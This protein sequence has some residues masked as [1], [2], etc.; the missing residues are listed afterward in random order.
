MPSYHLYPQ[1]HTICRGNYEITDIIITSENII[2]GVRYFRGKPRV[3]SF[4]QSESRKQCF[5]APDWLKFE[6]HPRKYRTL[7][8]DCKG[9]YPSLPQGLLK[10]RTSVGLIAQ[11]LDDLGITYFNSETKAKGFRGKGSKRPKK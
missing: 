5:L 4:N 9:Y 11:V 6:A 3:S 1:A 7:L 10:R 2:Y 8:D